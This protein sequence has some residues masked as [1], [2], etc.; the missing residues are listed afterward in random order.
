MKFRN[1]LSK[2]NI[3]FHT[4]TT[5]Q[6]NVL[7]VVLRKLPRFNSELILKKAGEQRL[8]S[9]FLHA[10]SEKPLIQIPNL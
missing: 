4:Y 2:H 10:N 5:V 1:Q 9:P 7:A 6:D 8:Q 3:E